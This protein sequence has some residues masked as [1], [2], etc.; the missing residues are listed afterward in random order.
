MKSIKSRFI[1]LG[2]AVAMTV[3]V[4]GVMPT[5]QVS[6]KAKVNSIV[7]NRKTATVYV[8]QEKS[9]K[10]FHVNGAK[11]TSSNKAVTYKIANKKIA[12]VSKKGIVKGVSK[13][14]T[15]VT[16][17]SKYNKKASAKVTVK[18]KQQITDITVTNAVKNTLVVRKGKKLKALVTVGPKNA[19]KKKVKFLSKNKKIFTV[20]KKTGIIKAKKFGTGKLVIRAVY[21][22]KNKKAR[23]TIKVIV[24]NKP[25]SAITA[26]VDNATLAPGKTANIA[27]TFAPAD[28][29]VKTVTYAT[30]DDKV[31][32]VSEDGVI[33]AVKPGKATITVTTLDGGLTSTIEITVPAKTPA[34]KVTD[35]AYTF[36]L[37]K[38]AMSYDIGYEGITYNIARDKFENDIMTL[39]KM[40]GNEKFDPQTFVKELSNDKLAKD[41]NIF[42]ENKTLMQKVMTV[43]GTDTE[44]KINVEGVVYTLTAT[45]DSLFLK[46]SN[47]VDYQ[48]ISVKKDGSNYVITTDIYESKVG[49]TDKYTIIISDDY[50]SISVKRG[51]IEVISIKIVDTGVEASFDKN[52]IDVLKNKY[53]TTP[54]F[55]HFVEKITIT[56]VYE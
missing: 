36:S 56:N 14:K 49:Y 12:T 45:K 19:N 33:T 52:F 41:F 5:E 32:T 21:A 1:A 3:T 16:V 15:T 47:E 50:K 4:A 17:T 18:V 26:K 44:K 10:L 20:N 46:R 29:T 2:M 7:L 35:S 6:A 8:G 24:P 55:I 39:A 48:K 13:G 38:N 23:K 27:L 22:P 28:A 30:S 11:P 42:G 9:I 25:V 54:L 43:S 34:S 31:A 53:P 37:D 40:F 51:S